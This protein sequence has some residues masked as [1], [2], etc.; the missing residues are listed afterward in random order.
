MFRGLKSMKKVLVIFLIIVCSICM[1]GC[2]QDF[3][4]DSLDDYIAFV[5]RNGFGNSTLE[6][7]H[8]DYFLPS[9][10]FLEDYDYIEGRYAWRDYDSLRE[11]FQKRVSP[12][13]TFLYLRY[14]E[15]V[16][17][18]AKQCMLDNIE[19]YN[20]L[21]YEYN[22]YIFY[23]NSNFIEQKRKRRFPE[24]FTMAC[25]NDKSYELVFIGFYAS[26]RTEKGYMININ[27]DFGA[28]I[29]AYYGEYHDFNQ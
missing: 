21:Y 2:Y 17:I 24:Y 14:E 15:E 3:S 29:N 28:F 5:K 4:S 10:T 19:P 7:D 8:P 6:L 13:I 16:Y 1:A 23:E 25:Y 11:L 27:N 26:V 18:N 22:D 20:E 9:D 12:D